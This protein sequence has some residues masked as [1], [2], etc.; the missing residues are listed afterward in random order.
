MDRN[1]C[2]TAIAFAKQKSKCSQSVRTIKAYNYMTQV[3]FPYKQITFVAGGVVQLWMSLSCPSSSCPHAFNL[4]SSLC[5]TFIRPFCSLSYVHHPITMCSPWLQIRS[6][7]SPDQL[8]YRWPNVRPPPSALS[9]ALKHV[10][11]PQL[12]LISCCGRRWPQCRIGG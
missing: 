11:Q 3:D 1:L 4:V 8:P 7:I 10:G 9:L 6:H 2:Q 12:L 5:H